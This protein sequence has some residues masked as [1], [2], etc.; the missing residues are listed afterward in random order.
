MNTNTDVNKMSLEEAIGYVVGGVVGKF[1]GYKLY[2]KLGAPK[3]VAYAIVVMSA[4]LMSLQTPESN[5]VRARI[6]IS[7]WMIKRYS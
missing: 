3:W 1:I 2:R 6:A 4:H 5:N 7:E